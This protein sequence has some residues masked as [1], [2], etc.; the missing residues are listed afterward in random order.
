MCV[1]MFGTK[2]RIGFLNIELRINV[3]IDE[4]FIFCG[5]S[6]WCATRPHTISL[7]A[8]ILKDATVNVTVFVHHFHYPK[9]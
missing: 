8:A 5:T 9:S 6:K 7:P 3:L 1:K 4:I 2:F